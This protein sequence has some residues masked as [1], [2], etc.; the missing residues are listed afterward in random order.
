ME[1]LFEKQAA[2]YLTARPGYPRKWFSKLAALSPHH[3]LAWDIGIGNVQATIGVAEPYKQVNAGDLSEEQ[4]K[5]AVP[6][7]QAVVYSEARPRYPSEWFSMLAALTPQHSVAWDVGTGNGQAAISV[8][9]VYE[10][11]IATDISDEQLKQ[12][13]PHPQVQ[14]VHTPLE[15]SD[16][17]L[18][19]LI[20]GENSVDL[21]TAATAVQWFDLDR[22]YPIVKRVLRKPGGIIAVWC[23]G[24]VEFSPEI[25]AILRRFSDLGKPFQSQSFKIASQ[26]Y[27]TLPFPFERVGVGCEGK[28]QELDMHKEMSF[29]GL[30]KFLS[31][32]PVVHIA[33][34][35]GVDLLPEE[36]L[37]DFERAW[38]EPESVRTATYKTYMLAGKRLIS[39]IDHIIFNNFD[40]EIISLIGGENSVD[41]VTVAQAVH[42]FDLPKFYSLVSRLQ[43]KPGGVLAVWCYNDAVVSPAFDSAFKRFHDSTLPFWHPNVQ[44]IFEGYKRLPFP[45]E[46]VGLGSEGKPL[47]LD[48]PK[49]LSFDG[50][51]KMIRSWSAVVTAKEQ[52]VDLLSQSVVQE[53]ETVWGGSKLVRSVIYKAFMLAGKVKL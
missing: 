3:Y 7:A 25:D 36:L 15:M 21:I 38:G 10:K 24:S 46:S 14:Y 6:H 39:S 40:D 1:G 23:Y 8:A 29:Q 9:E 51:L 5:H 33:K 17:E 27:K 35:Q 50:F 20:G 11:V 53:L 45:F 34:E 48:I 37:K 31:S 26:C 12:A 2:I 4:L 22:F 43:R 41:L 19:S 49:E 30:L 44:P 13:I 18:V 52:G 28:P 32:L 42:W 47:E 16:D